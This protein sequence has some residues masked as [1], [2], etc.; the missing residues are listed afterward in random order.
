ML[1]LVPT[2][3]KE[4][5]MTISLEVGQQNRF[6]YGNGIRLFTENHTEYLDAE[7]GTFNLSLGYNHP[8]VVQ[9]LQEQMGRLVH[10]SSQFT[11]PY[12]DELLEQLLTDAPENLGAGWMRDITG[13]T[14]N[15]CAVKLAQKY[16]GATDI[17][18]VFM[19]HH[20]QTLFA[21]GISGNAFRR[22]SFPNAAVGNNLSV[23]GPYC[24]RCHYKAT[25]PSCN[26]LCVDA[27]AE[28]I[29]YASSGSV[30]CMIIEPI[31]GNGGN[32]VPPKG[33]FE[34]L[35]KLCD[36][37][38]IML[39]ADEVQTG[40][41]RLGY[42]YASQVLDIKP[43][44]I[45]LAKGLGGI[46]V[47]VA[48]VLMEPALDT[49]KSYQHSFTSGSNMLALVA[50]KA[51]MEVISK[52]GFMENVRK[53][54]ELLGILLRELQEKHKCIG[55]VRGMGLMWGIEI[56]DESNLPDTKKTEAIID[57]AFN[58]QNLILRNSR[59]GFGNVIKV[60]PAL[61]STQDDLVEIVE[62]LA[63]A[64]ASVS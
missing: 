46:G 5:I 25:Y 1:T 59:Y 13:S 16:T 37:Y 29:E 17:I 18:S 21:T 32:V 48:A 45:T 15:E 8:H 22:E 40:L 30:A 53:N 58:E 50:A 10:M 55:D 63:S 34:K 27:I 6:Q 2:K 47:P 12:V 9:Q 60:R 64:I 3:F 39:I 38:N 20:G 51:T 24:Y 11:K 35:R 57:R 36:E 14:A 44:L 42:M 33:Y 23:P 49:F 7:S 56:V 41:G 19:S 54:G 26:L 61:I 4:E 28:F 31:L 43:N 62:R 52:P